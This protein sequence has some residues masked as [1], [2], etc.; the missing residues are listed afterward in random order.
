MFTIV[1]GLILL[2][3]LLQKRRIIFLIKG[4]VDPNKKSKQCPP[5]HG[6][7]HFFHGFPPLLP[8][9]SSSASELFSFFSSLCAHRLGRRGPAVSTIRALCFDALLPSG[10]VYWAGTKSGGSERP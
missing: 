2:V 9:R 4:V 7:G 6:D 10:A 1:E 5:P 3:I 8:L